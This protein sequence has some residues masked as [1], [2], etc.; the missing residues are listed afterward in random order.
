LAAPSI[1]RAAIIRKGSHMN[2][3]VEPS[4]AAGKRGL[5]RY[6]QVGEE[7]GSAVFKALKERSPLSGAYG[8]VLGVEHGIGFIVF[9]ENGR[10]SLIEGHCNG[11][12]PTAGFDFEKATLDLKP[13]GSKSQM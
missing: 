8:N 4:E 10:L 5:D 7:P 9:L 2:Y 12:A 3:A 6:L 11:N 1:G 13:W